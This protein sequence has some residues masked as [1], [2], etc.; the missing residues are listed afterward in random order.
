MHETFIYIEG[1]KIKIP[2]GCA[3]IMRGNLPHSGSEYNSY[4]VRLHMYIDLKVKC[5][6]VVG[7]NGRDLLWDK[8]AKKER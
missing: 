3:L 2:K 7:G 1:V 4:N 8:M 5:K 6:S